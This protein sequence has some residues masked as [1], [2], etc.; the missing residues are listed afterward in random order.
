MNFDYMTA[1][2]ESNYGTTEDMVNAPRHYSSEDG[3]E[4]WQ[5][6]VAAVGEDHFISHC[7]C[8]AIKYL[9]RWRKKGGIE[10]LKKAVWYI[11]KMIEVSDG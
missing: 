6:Q 10:S 5:A 9:W 11:N 8:N 1:E 3:L 2:E 7:Q 4:C